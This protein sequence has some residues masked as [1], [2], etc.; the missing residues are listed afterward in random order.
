MDECLNVRVIFPVNTPRDFKIETDVKDE[1]VAELI[2]EFLRCQIGAGEDL[3][4][5]NRLDV[6]TINLQ[7]DLSED[8]WYCKH[9]C[10]NLSL[11]DGILLDVLKRIDTLKG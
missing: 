11:R 4:P 8:V 1:L 5:S 3:S 7:L 6:Y 2:S 10:G 9:D